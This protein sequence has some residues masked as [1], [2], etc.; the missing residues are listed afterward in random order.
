M[1]LKGEAIAERLERA[2]S[3]AQNPLIITPSPG[4]KTLQYL[5]TSGSASIDLRL[6]TWFMTLRRARMKCLSIG[7]DLPEVQLSKTHYVPF[8]T[9]YILHPRCFVL[10]ASLEWVC[11][12]SD[13]AAYVVGKSS[14]GRRGLITATAAGVHPGWTGSLTLELSNVGEIPIAIT[15]GTTICQLFFHTVETLG[16]DSVD[17]SR[18]VGLRKPVLGAIALDEFAQR[19]ANAYK[20]H[21]GVNA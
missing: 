8:G 14:W 13:L 6:G 1:I 10:C 16:S 7:E 15:P 9:E 4:P 20:G 18:F 3:G 2:K 11:L 12:P 19:L 17:Q 21:G 5:R